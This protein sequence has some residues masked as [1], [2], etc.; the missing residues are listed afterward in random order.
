MISI[1]KRYLLVILSMF[2]YNPQD[3]G[4]DDGYVSTALSCLAAETG[5]WLGANLGT[6]LPCHQC[7]YTE[8]YYNTAVL[9]DPTGALAAVYHKVAPQH[10]W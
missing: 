10:Q 5:L 1:Y 6:V 9:F 4:P 2:P 8:C 7:N 3:G